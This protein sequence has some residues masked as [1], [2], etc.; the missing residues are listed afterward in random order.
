MDL[1]VLINL[2]VNLVGTLA[3]VLLA[4][5]LDRGSESNRSKT[6]YA[7]QLNAC[8]YEL[9][10]VRSSCNAIRGQLDSGAIVLDIDT[11]ALRTL[12]ASP[13]LQEHA[14]HGFIMVLNTLSAVG[15]TPIARI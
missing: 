15:I 13:G 6:E 2:G 10:L 8:R 11:P 3:G 7:Q 12:L 4:F 5:R 1:S 14:S 9:G